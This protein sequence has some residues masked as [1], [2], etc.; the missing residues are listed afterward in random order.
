MSSGCCV[1]DPLPYVEQLVIE[2][3][4]YIV[5]ISL[6]GV[7]SQIIIHHYYPYGISFPTIYNVAGLSSTKSK[8]HLFESVI[9]VKNSMNF[10]GVS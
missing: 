7:I 5:F 9:T 3:Y 8:L 1:P 4:I 2:I 10:R 6:L